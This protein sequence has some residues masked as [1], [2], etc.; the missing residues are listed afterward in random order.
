MEQRNC[1]F[2]YAKMKWG[3]TEI[4]YDLTSLTLDEAK[5]CWRD[6]YDDC[7]KWIKDGGTAEMVIWID[8]D[9]PTSYEKHL[10]YIST[11]ADSDGRS[12]WVNLR[13]TFKPQ[14]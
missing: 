5:A 2:Q 6:S 3:R 1:A 7:A 14:L 10:E 13:H 9:T 12:I 11:D 4:V 8:M